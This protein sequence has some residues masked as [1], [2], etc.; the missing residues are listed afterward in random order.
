MNL[1]IDY[2][3][4]DWLIDEF[5]DWWK[6]GLDDWLINWLINQ[7]T[8]FSLTGDVPFHDV[9]KKQQNNEM[10]WIDVNSPCYWSLTSQEFSG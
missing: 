9:S 7:L 2:F 5:I 8:L 1:L 10:R 3:L 6:N 4:I